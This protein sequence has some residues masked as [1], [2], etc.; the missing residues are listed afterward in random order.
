MVRH[1][2]IH[3]SGVA[4]NPTDVAGMNTQRRK[5][6]QKFRK[7]RS[8]SNLRHAV[9]GTLTMRLESVYSGVERKI[10]KGLSGCSFFGRLM[11]TGCAPS[12]S[13]HTMII[14]PL[15]QLMNS[16]VRRGVDADVAEDCSEHIRSQVNGGQMFC[17]SRKRQGLE[18]V[19]LYLI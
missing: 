18:G 5:R 4:I 2:S 11:P 3:D 8:T 10:C 17:E 16:R 9:F 7:Q 6:S 12:I 19:N 14:A 15:A 13:I 1:S